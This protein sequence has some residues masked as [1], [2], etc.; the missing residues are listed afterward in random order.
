MKRVGIE[1]LR[2]EIVDLRLE[3]VELV[4]GPLNGKPGLAEYLR[5]KALA[6]GRLLGIQASLP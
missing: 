5:V 4:W 2:F 1:D 3:M 6:R